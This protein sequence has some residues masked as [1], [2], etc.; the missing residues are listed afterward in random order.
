MKFQIW[1]L[2]QYLYHYRGV[3]TS[4]QQEDACRPAFLYVRL[5]Y[6]S[7]RYPWFEGSKT[8]CVFNVLPCTTFA[9]G[10]S[11]LL[12]LLPSEVSAMTVSFPV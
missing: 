6:L 1:N 7:G 12:F 9:I 5:N 10:A 2:F 3:E 4:L 8:F 11:I